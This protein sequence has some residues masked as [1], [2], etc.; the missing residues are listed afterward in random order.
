MK[1]RLLTAN[2]VVFLMLVGLVSYSQSETFAP[3]AY[4]IDMGSTSPTVNNSLKP[5]GLV[6]QLIVTHSVPVRWAINPVKVKDGIDFTVNSKNYRG[7]SFIIPA[8]YV[9]GTVL[10]TINTWKTKGVI[11]DGPI[12]I[13]FTA[14]VYKQ[15]T[16]W[17]RGVL[18][19]D[20]GNIVKAYYTRAEIPNS[21]F[22]EKGNPTLLTGCDDIYV[23]PHADPQKWVSSWK[24][25]LD[26]YIQNGGWFW[27]ACHAVSAV[28]ANTPT[29]LGFRYLSTSGLTPWG[30]HGD[31]SPNTYVYNPLYNSD[32]VMQFMGT[33]NAATTNGSEQ[34]YMPYKNASNWRPSTKVAVYQP[35]HT[36]A[37]PNEAAVVAYGPAYGNTNNGWVMYLGGHNH[38]GTATANIAAMRSYFNFILLAGVEKQVDLTANIPSTVVSGG[39]ISLNVTPSGG[40]PPYTY[41]WTSSCSGGTFSSPTSSSTTF[42]A[43]NVV[44]PTT[45]NITVTV[46]D[47]CGRVNIESTIITIN[48]PVGPTAQ[49]DNAS[50]DFNTPVTINILVNDIPGDAPL[51]PSSITFIPASVP[52]VSTGVFTVVNGQVVFTPSGTFSGTAT[53]Q[54]QVCDQNNLCAQA[55]IT[56]IVAPPVG[57]TANDDVAGTP[58]NT[59][60]T[61][62]ILE[63]DIPGTTP[64]VPSSVT[65]IPASI[66]PASEGVF[67]YNNVTGLVTFTPAPTFS[68]TTTIQY[69]VCDELNLCDQALITV[70]VGSPGGPTA[71]DDNASTPYNTPVTVNNLENDVPGSNPLVPTTVTLIPGTTPPA[72]EGVFTV[73]NVTGLITFTPA[74]GFSGTSTVQYQVCDQVNLC[75]QALVTV[76]VGSPGGPTANDD[77][78]TTPYNTPV[79]INN[80]E[81][82]VPG[83]SPLVA[84]SVT[85]IPGTTPPA[86]EGVF[87]VNELTGLITFTPAVGFSGTSTVQ[88]QVC[89]QINLCDIALVTVVVVPPVLGPTA[90]NDYTLTPVNTPVLINVLANDVPGSGPIV[91]STLILTGVQPNP[92]TEGTFTVD[93]ITWKVIF[94]PVNGFTGTVT[95]EYQI[96]DE[97][98]LCDIATIT[99]D[100]FIGV[101]NLYPAFGPGT[102]AYEDLWPGKGDYDFNDLVLDYQFEIMTNTENYVEQLIGTFTIRA[103]GASYENGFGFQLSGT[104]DPADV[105][106]IGTNLSESFIV[107]DPNGAEANQSKPTIIVYDNAFALMPHPGIGIGVNT[108]QDAPYVDPVTLTINI[109]FSQNTYTINQ[110]DIANFNPFLIV[111]KVRGHEVHLPNYPPTDLADLSLFGMWE[112]DSDPL[113]GKY[114]LTVNN[115]P[116]AINIYES[117]DYPKEKQ[118][119][120][121]AHLKF[122]E[123]ATSGGILFP[124]WYKNLPGYRNNNLIY[125]RPNN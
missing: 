44:T 79:T 66:P 108:E 89:D 50:T 15:L 124:D 29:Y 18:D 116:W 46:T 56:V 16:S 13:S 115:L 20:N 71:N 85:L 78:A 105:A 47:N 122:A 65:F 123:W 92:V 43:P 17:P 39:T 54:Y 60:V 87:T 21:S 109:L 34:I 114:Y 98:S 59:P 93:V 77:N 69:Q 32:P 125:Q 24:T 121:W 86:S 76:V 91:P 99:V 27:A 2:L 33:L 107:L 106:V 48:P 117:F 83:S 10:S 103:F 30:S 26:N 58:Y 68:G 63:D 95:G 35:T 74:V 64:L 49:N 57:P 6:Y 14:P 94:T 90:N 3:G 62:D 73:N 7:G 112:D 53:V 111:N 70:N 4:I 97:N 113:T 61:F 75:D 12:N 67:T 40:N 88:Y 80:L 118:E 96:C 25:A 1:I 5:Y 11:V 28:E 51:V 55:L 110:L 9:N 37:N 101:T 81:N 45:C 72:S 8:S 82:D 22:V 41:I 84:T 19:S 120:I 36:N 42:T 52:P 31:G 38:D 102:L 104:I 23:M 119:V 100:V